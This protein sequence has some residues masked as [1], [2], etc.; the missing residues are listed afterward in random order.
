MKPKSIDRQE[1]KRAAVK[2]MVLS[3]LFQLLPI[4]SGQRC[5][6]LF[7]PLQVGCPLCKK[8]LF[9]LILIHMHPF[10]SRYP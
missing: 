8:F 7:Q 3:T 5:L 2:S 6:L 9:I 10:S 4:L 1:E